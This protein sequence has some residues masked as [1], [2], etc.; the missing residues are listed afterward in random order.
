MTGPQAQ[1]QTPAYPSEASVT[2]N[3]SSRAK[4]PLCVSE[5]H[6]VL[7][8]NF[9]AP[10]MRGVFQEISRRVRRLTILSSVAVESNRQ[11]NADWGELDVRVQ[12]TWTITCHPKHPG[13][14]RDV[15]YIHVPLDTISQLKR[16]RGDV[17]VSLELGARSLL[18]TVYRKLHPNCAHLIAVNASERSE[19]G[20]GPIRERLRRRLLRRADWITYNGPSCRRL[21]L[22]LGADEATMSAWD[23]AADPSK[24]YRGPLTRGR[25]NDRSQL[26]LLTVGELSERKG[27][28][29][30]VRQ[31]SS[32]ASRNPER[33]ID[34]NLVGAGP[35]ESHLR[36]YD[37]PSNLRLHFHGFCEPELIRDHYRDHDFL[38]FPTLADEWG[39]VVDESLCSGLP[40]IGSC[41]AQAITTLI[42]DGENGMT[43]D[44]EVEE[45]LSSR[46]DRLMAMP[47]HAMQ[48]MPSAARESSSERTCANSADQFAAAVTS[49][50][51]RRW[52]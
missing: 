48:A 34:W 39:L 35:L 3:S 30:A 18:S 40:V 16:L 28:M 14:Y 26:S 42:R 21:L 9:V 19:A 13:G 49:A 33:T 27:V 5:A 46:L 24:P 36:Q 8:V 47:D 7:L 15:N 10:N 1:T 37:V 32:W 43:Y 23:Y 12:K 50:I 25:P 41:H 45:S 20:R 29:L 22:A 4:D 2:G 11:W 44:P 38:L 51:A 6:V 17:V 31:L 52:G